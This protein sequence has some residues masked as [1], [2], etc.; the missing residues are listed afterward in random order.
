M[1]ETGGGSILLRPLL[2]AAFWCVASIGVAAIALIFLFRAHVTTQIGDELT[3][4]GIR[5]A[6][7]TEPDG[8]GSYR[9]RGQMA[10]PRYGRPLSGWVWQA[11]RDGQVILQSASF[12]PL[13]A[14]G[15]AL[16]TSVGAVGSFEGQGGGLARRITP[17][18]S[19]ERLSFVVARPSDGFDAAVARFRAGAVR[20]GPG[21]GGLVGENGPEDPHRSSQLGRGCAPR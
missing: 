14:G 2:I 16:P 18:F 7:L 20:G 10:D 4:Q 12:G 15:N 3:G 17:R 8:A 11:S 21:D 1:A 13:G 6:S 5:L 9:L 19:Q